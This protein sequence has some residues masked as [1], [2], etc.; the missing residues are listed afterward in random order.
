MVDIV[1]IN[2]YLNDVLR[3]TRNSSEQP[4]SLPEHVNLLLWGHNLACLEFK[5]ILSKI[6]I[7]VA[8]VIDNDKKK[9]GKK[10]ADVPVILPK[11]I[12][13][14][15][16]CVIVIA[17]YSHSI[18]ISKQLIQLG[19]V[20]QVHFTDHFSLGYENSFA[21]T[22]FDSKDLSQN[23]ENPEKIMMPDISSQN[24]SDE[25]FITCIWHDLFPI[26]NL[27]ENKGWVKKKINKDISVEKLRKPY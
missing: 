16:P 25:N 24:F 27:S 14:Y 3:G 6:G 23:E 2:N 11:D 9:T 13:T 5:K 19:F 20:Y 21:K 10:I 7:E 26:M 18:E 4:M 15:K 17:S 8:A 1:K 12:D 22:F